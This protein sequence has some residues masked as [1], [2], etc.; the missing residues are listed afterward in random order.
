MP[1]DPDVA[2]VLEK[3][4]LAG[5]PEYWQMTPAE[6]RDWHNRKAGMLDIKPAAVH[7]VDDRAIPGPAAPIAVRIYTPRAAYRPLPVLVWLHGGGHVVG[8]LASYDPLCRQLALQSDS[9]VVS[10][11]YRLAPEHRFPA[12]VD[13]SIAALNWA[14][15]NAADFGGDAARIAV[16]GD[17]AGGNLAA[18]CAILARDAGGPTLRFQLLVYPRTAPEEDAP[19]HFTFADGYLLTRK[20]ILWFHDH[21]RAS[22]DDRKDFRYAP[23]IC[24]D[25]S[26]LPPALVIVGEFDPLRDDGI[27]YADRLRDAGNDVELAD[28]PG[29]VHPFFS[30][31]GAVAAGRTALTRAA[32]ALRRAFGSP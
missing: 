29:M 7:R 24:P 15:A 6:A 12:G 23:L 8:S 20:T 30:M 19:S 4:R 1:V 17:S 10:V 5:N 21:Y 3:I 18:V 27:A 31:G 14:A 32:R 11:D 28:Y 26:R 25:L 2:A 22:P 9:I 16:G 13:D